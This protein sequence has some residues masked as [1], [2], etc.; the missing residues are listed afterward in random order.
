[1]TR[2]GK[3]KTKLEAQWAVPVPLLAII[4]N[5]PVLSALSAYFSADLFNTLMSFSIILFFFLISEAAWPNVSSF[6]VNKEV[7][8]EHLAETSF[9]AQRT[10]VDH[11]S[12]VD[13][14]LKV[15]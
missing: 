11:V 14:F 4:A 7:S 3:Q 9:V 6:L 10:I 1:M 8:V 5:F 12:S 2:K 13:V 15:N